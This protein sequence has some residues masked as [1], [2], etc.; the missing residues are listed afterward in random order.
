MPNMT[1][2][3]TML[4]VTPSAP[5]TRPRVPAAAAGS[6]VKRSAIDPKWKASKT[7][8]STTSI[9]ATVTRARPES[10]APAQPRA[11]D[12]CSFLSELGSGLTARRS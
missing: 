3:K 9:T 1:Q 10:I 12:C 4:R 8:N 7:P 6:G 11:A 5:P 2:I